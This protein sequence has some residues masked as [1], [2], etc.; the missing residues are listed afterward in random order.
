MG[1]L[2]LLR[3]P[4]KQHK[5]TLVLKSC[6]KQELEIAGIVGVLGHT[7]GPHIILPGVLG[8]TPGPHIMQPQS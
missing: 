3:I 2:R 7:P 5:T 4:P 8:H 6:S 1:F